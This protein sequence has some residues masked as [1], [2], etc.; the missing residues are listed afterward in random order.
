GIVDGGGDGANGERCREE[1]ARES[2]KEADVPARVQRRPNHRVEVEWQGTGRRSAEV[3]DARRGNGEV[4]K[5]EWG[6]GCHPGRPADP[7][8]YRGAERSV[9][10]RDGSG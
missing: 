10:R 7:G 9:H 8:P 1:P 2:G 6:E 5:A 3:S 4:G